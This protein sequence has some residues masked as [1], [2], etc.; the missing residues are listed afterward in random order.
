[1]RSVFHIVAKDGFDPEAAE[2]KPPS[3]VSEGFVHLSRAH[4]VFATLQR[5]FKDRSDVL[6]LHLDRDRLTHEVKDEP[7]HGENFPHHYGP[8]NLSALV[9]VLDLGDSPRQWPKA[10]AVVEDALI[11][12]AYPGD[13]A[14]IANVHVHAWQQSYRGLVPDEVLRVLPRDFARRRRW[15]KAASAE[16]LPARVFVAESARFGVIG[17]CAVEPAR[18][19]TFE[20]YGEIT[21]IY[22]LEEFKDKGIGAALFRA[23]RESLRSMG[24]DRHYLWVLEGN[25]T[26]EFYGRMGGQKTPHQKTI[27]LGQPL[28]ELAFEFI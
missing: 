10:Y 13:E 1:M 18:D 4:Q 28:V 3:L 22:C 17:F 16:S 23:G 19:K 2:I 24:F 15:W 7:A 9:H 25:P 20:G 14:E 26:V 27:E 12:K 11:R 8:L 6:V 21:A 5:H